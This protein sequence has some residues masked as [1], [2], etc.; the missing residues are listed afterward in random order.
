MSQT[1]GG[2]QQWFRRGGGLVWL[3][4]VVLCVACARVRP[5]SGG[6]PDTTP[7]VLS[8]FTPPDSSTGLPRNTVFEF[9]FD[10]AVDR[11]SAGAAIRTYPHT[12]RREVEVKGGH[13]TVRFPDS[14]P[15]DT[16][17]VLVIGKALQDQK[18]RNNG[19]TQE[20]T[21]IYSTADTI[22]DAT[23]LGRIS[24]KGQPSA[25]GAVQYEPVPADTSKARPPR[26]YPFAATNPEG[27]FRMVGIPPGRP[28]VLRG[29]EDRNH[30]RLAD[31]EELQSVLPET[32]VLQAGQVRRA[33]EWNLIDPFE[34]GSVEGVVINRTGI[35]ARVAIALQP[36]DQEKKQASD[37][38]QTTP[39]A[40]GAGGGRAS[41]APP[42]AT[43]VA[44]D[45]LFPGFRKL[46][47]QN[48]QESGYESAYALLDSTGFKASEWRIAYATPRGDYTIKVSPGRHWIVAF[49]DVS[50]D[51][52]PGLYVTA[53]SSARHWEPLWTGDTLF[54]APGEKFRATTIDLEAK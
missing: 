14:L 54:V 45:S 11:A 23:V 21:F 25:Q 22:R 40:G 9:F 37:A 20:L 7:P 4:T 19:L 33:V 16:T 32:L 12:V 5:L 34:K 29:F 43:Q 39:A 53:D 27:L 52:M 42:A 1:N 15:A 28:F 35:D 26:R 30:N 47:E 24:V 51:S 36:L 50:R 8:R 13:I 46:P 10:E 2:L 49:V 3:L 6:N 31:L 18:P 17:F 38:P 44:G 48:R 41:P